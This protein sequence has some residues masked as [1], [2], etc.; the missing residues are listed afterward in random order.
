MIHDVI[1]WNI[2]W[3]GSK[4]LK[5]YYNR[6][7][8]TIT[9]LNE[10]W[11]DMDTTTVKYGEVPTHADPTQPA[12][13]HYTYKFK[14]WNPEPT[15]ATGEIS[16]RATYEHI[17]NKHTITWKN[18]DGS[19]ID[20]TMVE[21]GTIP[22][23]AKP[24]K[25]ETEDYRYIFARWDPEV[26][27]VVWDAEYTAVFN[28]EEKEKSSKWGG[29]SGWG[30]RWWNIDNSDNQ[31]WSAEENIDWDEYTWDE[32]VNDTDKNIV[33]LYKRVHENDIT[34][35]D[36]LEYADPDWLL[37]RWHL[38]KMVV[39][40]MVNVLWRKIPYDVTYNCRYWGDDESSRESDEIRDYATKACA[41]WVMWINMEDNKFLPNSIVTRAEF[42]TV[43]SRV[44]R[45]DK[46][47]ITDTDNRSYY[48]NHLQALKKDNIL[49]QIANPET[50]WEIRK[51]VWLVFRR[52]V[53]KYKK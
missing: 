32:V 17:V 1:T 31:H 29:M 16:Y 5:M 23:H 3:D 27:A 43:M 24:T 33:P 52:I 10:D 40:Y 25:T 26:V 20:K 35:M 51:W 28:T 48:E 37:T 18:D 49:T 4:V 34:T 46:Y 30:W 15:F 12:D 7:I 11:T 39:N 9:W 2:D 6:E 44:L 22:T 41:F 42:W 19:V 14:G 47:D 45:W 50:R 21:Y 53:E 8:Y 36:T 13:A 38:A